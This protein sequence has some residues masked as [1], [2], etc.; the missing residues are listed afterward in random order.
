MSLFPLPIGS[1]PFDW[2]QALSYIDE[3]FDERIKPFGCQYFPPNSGNPGYPLKT[4]TSVTD[5]HD[6]TVTF[7]FS[8]LSPDWTSGEW[9][10]AGHEA[11]CPAGLRYYL[12]VWVSMGPPADPY[13]Q[14]SGFITAQ[15]QD[16]T[17]H[18]GTLTV[19]PSSGFL[20][21]V[22]AGFIS[23]LS[24]LVGKPYAI[25][26]QGLATYMDRRWL[27]PNDHEAA[28]GQFDGGW[29]AT[30]IYNSGTNTEAFD[31][32]GNAPF[33]PAKIF[34]QAIS[35][36]HKMAGTL[37]LNADG[38]FSSATPSYASSAGTNMPNLF[39]PTIWA[40]VSFSFCKPTFDSA[41]GIGQAQQFIELYPTSPYD[42]ALGD[43]P[44]PPHTNWKID[45]Y[46]G[47]DFLAYGN[48]GSVATVF[49]DPATYPL[50]LGH[51][52]SSASMP[53]VGVAGDGTGC[54]V[55]P[56][57]G[58]ISDL[59]Y[60]LMTN[61]GAGY[62]PPPAAPPN[63]SVACTTGAAAGVATV[64]IAGQVS[65][66]VAI[67]SAD[68]T[69]PVVTI[70]AAPMGGTNAT[71]NGILGT[72]VIEGYNVT[73][74]GNGFTHDPL[75][76]VSGGSGSGATAISTL[77]GAT[78]LL[79]T[80]SSG[81]RPKVAG[82]DEGIIYLGKRPSD[83][84][85][86][87]P[88]ASLILDAGQQF[89]VLKTGLK[90]MPGR[91]PDVPTLFYAG[92]TD[93]SV[94][95]SPGDGSL[96]FTGQMAGDTAL[97]TLNEDDDCE[98][99][100]FVS[101]DIDITYPQDVCNCGKQGFPVNP[102][103]W[104][105]L[106]A[107]QAFA[108]QLLM[109]YINPATIGLT[110]PPVPYTFTDIMAAIGASSSG[111]DRI[112][113]RQFA[114]LYQISTFEEDQDDSGDLI[115]PPVVDP[116]GALPDPGAITL[117][118]MP[119]GGALTR[120]TTFAYR[121]SWENSSGETLATPEQ[122]I[123]TPNVGPDTYSISVGWAFQVGAEDANVYG[124]TASGELL[125]TT[126]AMPTLSWVDDGSITPSGELPTS[127]TTANACNGA[128][129]WIKHPPS[130]TYQTP[131]NFGYLGEG[132]PTLVA[133]DFARYM[134]DNATDP[135]P[136]GERIT[137][138]SAVDARAF[139]GKL[140]K[141]A[142]LAR[143]STQKGTV[144]DSTKNYIF[145]TSKNWWTDESNNGT[146]RIQG[147]IAASGSGT[148]LVVAS[149]SGDSL[150][151]WNPGRYVGFSGI[152]CDFILE[153]YEGGTPAGWTIS[154]DGTA[155]YSAPTPPGNTSIAGLIPIIT[156]VGPSLL[157]VIG[158]AQ[159]VWFDGM[160][161]DPAATIQLTNTDTGDIF[162]PTVTVTAFGEILLSFNFGFVAA[163]WSAVVTNPGPHTSTAFAFV[164][165]AVNYVPITSGTI[166]GG[167][168]TFG[169]SAVSGLSV[170]GG[171]G[172]LIREPGKAGAL[173]KWMQ[174][175]VLFTKDDGTKLKI[176]ARFSAD[177]RLFFDAQS[178][179]FGIGWT[180]EILEY[181]PGAVL[182][183]SSSA[184]TDGRQFVE[185]V[186][187]SVYWSEPY[188]LDVNG[189]IVV[190]SNTDT[191]GG[192]NF[193]LNLNNNLATKVVGA[194]YMLPGDEFGAHILNQIHDILALARYVL[195]HGTWT[196][197]GENNLLSG[198]YN[199]VFTC[200]GCGTDCPPTQSFSSVADMLVWAAGTNGSVS[201]SAGPP[202][203]VNMANSFFDG[204][205]C[206]NFEF[207]GSEFFARQYA[208]YD[209][210]TIDCL[211][212]ASITLYAKSRRW[213]CDTSDQTFLSQ[214]GCAA[215]APIGDGGPPYGSYT[216]SPGV[217]TYQESTLDAQGDQ[218]G[219]DGTYHPWDVQT[220]KSDGT[221][222]SDSFAK[223]GG[224]QPLSLGPLSSIADNVFYLSGYKVIDDYAI[225]DMLPLIHYT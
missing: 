218:V 198:D 81:N 34:F 143:E 213:I 192:G 172:W 222:M 114:H 200:I 37:I 117:T 169:F 33:F 77:N 106:R 130:T 12:V 108:V 138:Y 49:P 85:Y 137:V 182:K 26:Q 75:I 66:A 124:R 152:W 171:D 191:R 45:L 55:T 102:N 6:G 58:T 110:T 105:T 94:I 112:S 157:H 16:A 175:S 13:Q 8:G 221:W 163:N 167:T 162:N 113:R 11:D 56:K 184:P 83:P 91:N 174:R 179:P 133:D 180:Y 19:S 4:V 153:V 127:N 109:N 156:S 139:R 86:A 52:Y 118:V 43:S 217:G 22:T 168:G 181:L 46:K 128:G 176:P 95:R 141:T 177:Q 78:K 47:M 164:T 74:P 204:L 219:T 183:F 121:V 165:H 199:D 50:S 76:T 146:L 211:V 220:I 30:L 158:T 104:K 161:F 208:Y 224:G 125:M 64:N 206:Y 31:T 2:D 196:G 18:T 62:L 115:D 61:A 20:N 129:T 135:F 70:D 3:M 205:G 24:S 17:T 140:W 93:Q 132:G 136:G 142:Q 9:T 10:G 1:V 87:I 21:A 73:N 99:F 79:A 214:Q 97:L 72:E 119:T 166:T 122:T 190:G 189:E 14:V 51:G 23:S 54:T 216:Y 59:R 35:G 194:G 57:L 203:T 123:T 210:S 188:I 44:Q 67:S 36:S 84:V 89:I 148:T 215:I 173:N 27:K 32:T 29:T 147:G 96:A 155:T 98:N 159:P 107:H 100:E 53:T 145:D 154:A 68:V 82:N 39:D 40:A 201:S 7:G 25:I 5:N 126:V 186:P 134:G 160:F 193:V 202:Y 42:N 209:G 38:S 170:S 63:I 101:Q 65:I 195:F 223:G 212:G 151:W 111:L 90:G 197:R 48:T 149:I 15:T 185:S 103:Y 178:V 225:L 144:V 116:G 150:C 71:A 28:I 120:N 80:D 41:T 69:V 187:G 92:S 88:S 131:T 60:F 207:D